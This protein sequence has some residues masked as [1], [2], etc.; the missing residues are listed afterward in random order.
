MNS[1]KNGVI[2]C[3]AYAS[4]QITSSHILKFMVL[5]KTPSPYQLLVFL[6]TLLQF[7]TVGVFNL[8]TYRLIF[9]VRRSVSGTILPKVPVITSCTLRQEFSDL[10]PLN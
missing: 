3:L 8:K 4:V 6:F 5:Q 7:L 2:R 1:P 9:L 10:L